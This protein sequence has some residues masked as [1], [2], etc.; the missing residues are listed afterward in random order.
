MN[1]IPKILSASAPKENILLVNFSNGQTRIFNVE[2]VTSRP[3]YNQ[4]LNYSFLKNVKVDPSGYSIYW[5]DE[6][7][8][9]ENELW[10]KGE[11][12]T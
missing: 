10:Q 2:T 12:A 5:N 3:N 6:I 1:N 7:D 4:L 8:L 11:P 9:C